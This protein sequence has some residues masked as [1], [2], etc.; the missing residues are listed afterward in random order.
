MQLVQEPATSNQ[1]EDLD[2][3]L[4]ALLAAGKEDLVRS[5]T[6]LATGRQPGYGK[7]RFRLQRR[8]RLIV[9]VCWKLRI[10]LLQLQ[11]ILQ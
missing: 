9:R 10:N 8:L 5:G 6:S 1:H 2:G 7:G 11:V 3:E 4:E